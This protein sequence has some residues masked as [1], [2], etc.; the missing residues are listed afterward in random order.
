MNRKDDQK[1]ASREASKRASREPK[2]E[3]EIYPRSNLKATGKQ[4]KDSSKAAE[5]QHKKAA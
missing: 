5:K 1:E 4:Q 2:N 3:A